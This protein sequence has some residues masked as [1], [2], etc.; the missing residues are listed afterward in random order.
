MKPPCSPSAFFLAV[1]LPLYS[2]LP[3]SAWG[4]APHFPSNTPSVAQSSQK[5][6][7]ASSASIT[8]PGP[9]RS[10]LRMAAISQKVSP[11]E[12]LPLLARNAAME[13]YGW[14]G[15]T[16]H[17][18][19]YLMLLE[20]YLKHAKELMAL[21]G[22]EHIIRVSNCSEAQPLLKILGYRLLQPCGPNT[23]VETANPKRAFLTVDSGFP[24]T[25]LVEKLQE[26]KPFAYPFPTSYVPILFN[27][28][29]W[30]AAEKDR[31]EHKKERKI[32]D[33]DILNAFVRDPALARLYWALAQMDAN[34][35]AYLRQSPGL[36]K[37]I[38]SAAVLD[39]YGS[40]I[41]IRSGRVVVPGG[42]PAESAW[43]SL[44][45]SSPESPSA[46]ITRLLRKDQGWLAA[47]FDALSRV[48]GA[49]QAYFTERRR[50][51]LFYQA[52]RGRHASPGAARPV[53]R[54]NAGLLLLVTQFQL[55]PTGQPSI[56]GNLE[57]WKE[58]FRGERK[59][60]SKT[61]RL[62]AKRAAGWNNPGQLVASMFAISR[63]SSET[64]PLQIYLALSDINRGRI[65]D[66]RLA[67][68]TALLL[69]E[70]FS[71]FGGQYPIFSEFHALNDASIIRFL[72]V[73]ESLDGIHERTL[74]ADALGI[75]QAN[76]GLWQILARQGQIPTENWNESWQQV[77]DPFAS[78]RSSVQLVDAA[79]SSLG[80]LLRAAAGTPRLSQDEIITLL[81]GPN[82]TSPEGQAVKEELTGKIRA[83]L[84][85]QRLV[86][87][88][89]L[90][91]LDDDL[92][93]M[94][95]GEPLPQRLVRLAGDLREFRTPKPLFTSSERADW[96][97][98]LY[99]NP[100]IQA[101]TA[102]DLVKTVKLSRSAKELAAARGQLIPFLRDTLVG[103]N[104]AYYQPPGS[105]LLYNDPLLVR[106]H[107]FSDQMFMGE[108]QGWK[109]P[110]VVGRGWTASGGVHLDGS[111]ADLPYALAEVEQD[112][113]VPQNVQA[114]IWEDLA[115]TLLT[116]SVV[117][118]WWRVTRNELHAVS[119]YQQSGE[120]LLAAASKNEKLRQQTVNILSDRM[121]PRRCAQVDEAL[122]AGRPE[123]A[124]SQLTPADTFYLAA[125]FMQRFP[126]DANKWGQAAQELEQLSQRYPKEVSWERL[127]K[128]FGAPHPA[129]AQTYAR[130]MLNVQPFPSFLGYSS[131]LLAESWE[132]N[133]LYWARLADE[134]GYSPVMLNLLIPEL[135]R[136][137]VANIFATDL[138]DRPA[139][140]RALRQT[141]EE[142]R[143]GKFASLPGGRAASGL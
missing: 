46:F 143:A 88:D 89:T 13:G 139:I 93:R 54:P 104:Y 78:I 50:L 33:N 129:L 115:P 35:A 24:L 62:W 122:R 40:R 37:L 87:L 12:V 125:E 58:I 96:S 4:K 100:H 86:S 52:L 68:Q 31:I 59:S 28:G 45:G 30:T 109:T 137:M 48:S 39:F 16:P 102:T 108:G 106:S 101:E 111:L 34:T 85:A 6:P 140:L 57:V 82:Q 136:H 117:P 67:P 138:E 141:G 21:A 7:P 118:R 8:V 14:R 103:L 32:K 55:D 44:V 10:V 17:P 73:A 53:F 71:Q 25:E 94:T 91:A 112:F 123:G 61:V 97:Y 47:Y 81:A 38:P 23:S 124:L 133:N 114:L 18:T 2:C 120:E 36:E 42:I 49:P 1:F 121:S 90:F 134:N 9:L 19:E 15:K 131:R 84:E 74:R 98:G 63:V 64:S 130:E 11:D 128:D 142:F 77:I 22:P 95:P 79:R 92:K 70:K 83:V 27:S 105:H 66:Q 43:K 41:Y 26:G 60:N 56:P 51:R 76:V 5:D 65:P 113:I 119:L 99:S 116:D 3:G 135:T 107:D 110:S 80:E 132:S 20:G 72:S 29:V 127:S 126:D 69:G 75:M